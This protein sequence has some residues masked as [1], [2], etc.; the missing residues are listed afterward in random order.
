MKEPWIDIVDMNNHIH[1]VGIRELLL[2]AHMLKA[3]QD[4]SPLYEY[5]IYRLLTVLVM[6]IFS[7]ETTFDLRDLLEEGKFNEVKIDEYISKCVEENNCFDLFDSKMPFL[8][9]AYDPLVDKTIKPVAVMMHDLPSGNNHLHFK[10]LTESS[11]QYSYAD[12]TKALTAVNVFCTAGLQGPSSVNGAPPIYVMTKGKTLFDTIVCNC[13]PISATTLDYADPL[14]TWRNRRSFNPGEEV[15]NTSLLEGMTFRARRITLIPNNE[16]VGEMYFQKGI[17]FT[18][19][20]IWRDPHTIINKE[21]GASI[22]PR[23]GKDT[24]RN[25]GLIFGDRKTSP[26]VVQQ[27]P[28]LEDKDMS[29]VVTYGLITNQASYES[30][31]RDEISVPI[32]ITNDAIRMDI[33][34]NAI[35]LS[36]TMAS[37][38]RKSLKMISD[39]N[40]V[41]EESVS[42][43]YENIR[44]QLFTVLIPYLENQNPFDQTY[45]DK[46][47]ILWKECVKKELTTALER[48]A[49]RMGNRG[50]DLKNRAKA[51]REI[52]KVIG[53]YLKEG[54]EKVG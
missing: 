54:G 29:R 33:T 51:N 16:F 20:G 22:K 31:F 17:N 49:D 5:G 37:K 42:G 8:Q 34:N 35:V 50:I 32:S 40:S 46:A 14:P 45:A 12:C 10:H 27:F 23:Q 24:W 28:E 44:R 18:G 26:I 47:L 3:I 36:E 30:W 21:N 38:L 39:W 9:V 48:G 4:I 15:A 52:G 2:N 6:D 43:Y 53:I 11:H 41:I 19:Y 25:I 13:I 1:T 7:P